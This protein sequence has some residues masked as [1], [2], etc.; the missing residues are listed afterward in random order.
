M[1]NRNGS[2]NDDADDSFTEDDFFMS[3]GWLWPSE[4]Q[5][6]WVQSTQEIGNDR[7]PNPNEAFN[8]ESNEEGRRWT[9]S[10]STTSSEASIITATPYHQQHVA[11]R[12]ATESAVDL[13]NLPGYVL[14]C[15]QNMPLILGNEQNLSDINLTAESLGRD[16]LV[17]ATWSVA[18]S[19]ESA[20][21]RSWTIPLRRTATP[22]ALEETEDRA[23][24]ERTDDLGPVP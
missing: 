5:E 24:R 18:E 1:S 21:L 15:E 9:V 19:Q 8:A 20:P 6:A 7:P 11:S 23:M 16:G 12:D 14:V 22:C 4:E 2:L 10:D 13:T 17:P 3:L